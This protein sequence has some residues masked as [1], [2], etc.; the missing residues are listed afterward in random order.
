MLERLRRLRVRLWKLAFRLY[1]AYRGTGGRI[2]HIEPDRARV[3]AE[4]PLNWWTHN[5]VVAGFAGC[6]RGL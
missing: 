3:E 5:Y 2:T 1:P 4:L 6:T